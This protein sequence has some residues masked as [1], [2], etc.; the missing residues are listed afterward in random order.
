[1][2]LHW[3]LAGAW[4]LP[5][6][7]VPESQP[8]GADSEQSAPSV[9]SI[10]SPSDPVVVEFDLPPPPVEHDG[11]IEQLPPPPVTIEPPVLP[12]VG[13]AAPITVD[14]NTAARSTVAPEEATD[15]P[16]PSL[17]RLDRVR[18]I[19][20]LG[21]AGIVVATVGVTGVTIGTLFLRKGIT[22]DPYST[23]ESFN[24]VRDYT[25]PGWML[26]GAGMGVTAIGAIALAIDVT[27]GRERRVR[28][29]VIRP[30]FGHAHAGLQL[31]GQ[32]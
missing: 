11:P 12:E 26:Y 15:A 13:R 4:V 30:Q 31:R 32:F 3:L 16:A 22:T 2:S 17:P 5:A 27:A 7:S 8:N 6:P 14:R 9:P 28:R 21:A 25:R 29:M 1:M 24:V 20:S 23:D 18:W 10:A 19:S